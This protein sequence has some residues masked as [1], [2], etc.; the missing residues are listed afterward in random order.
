MPAKEISQICVSCKE[1]E[2]LAT[3]RN[4]PLCRDCFID[5][6]GRKVAAVM[7]AYRPQKNVTPPKVLLPLSLGISSSSLLHIVDRLQKFQLN[8]S[9]ATAGFDLHVLVVDPTTVHPGYTDVKANSDSAKET[10]PNHTYTMIPLHR[11]FEYDATINDTLRDFGFVGENFGSDKE[12]L[13]AFRASMSTTTARDDIDNLLLVRL[14]V[15]FAKNNDCRGILWGDSDS[16]LAAKT[17][18]NVAKGRGA[19]LTWQVCDGVSPWGLHF[20]FPLRELYKFE[21]EIYVKQIP[22]LASIIIPDLQV[23]ENEANRNLS[24]DNLMNLYVKTQGEKYPGVMAN[25]VRTANKLRP[26]SNTEAVKC[27]L[28]A[29]PVDQT[30]TLCYACLRS[31]ADVLQ[32]A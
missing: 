6:A 32:H 13:D 18:A 26:T 22:E 14:I 3:I 29:A 11:I 17:L 10:F 1:V 27:S 31:R 9:L 8:R 4:R 7:S 24:I 16:R 12:R 15:A 30:A 2:A 19:S 25:V 21:L 5:Y 23:Q 20:S 28:C